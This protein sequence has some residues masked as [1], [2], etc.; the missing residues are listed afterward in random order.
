M[1]RAALLGLC[2][3]AALPVTAAGQTSMY[4][5][6]GMTV[7]SDIVRDVILTPVTTRPGLAPTLYAGADFAIGPR[8]RL[9]VEAS[10]ATAS[11]TT[12]TPSQ[13]GSDID[14]GRIWTM[15]ALLNM[16]GPLASRIG[17]RAGLGLLHYS[18][19]GDAGIFAEGGTTRALFGVG[20]DYQLASGRTWHPVISA[21]YDYHRFVTKEMRSQGF[22]LEQGVQ[23]LSLSVG[24]VRGT[25]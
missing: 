20:L 10:A 15:G 11:L 7:S 22:G 17:W 3:G 6:A 21:R 9:G 4:A 24:L 8:Y 19:P 14:Q 18:G 23:R 12:T 5:R 16:S 13:P 2:A 25:P 1:L